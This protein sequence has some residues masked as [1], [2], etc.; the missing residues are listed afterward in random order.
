MDIRHILGPLK[1]SM[2]LIK[3]RNDKYYK[4]E[5]DKYKNQNL[6]NS[7][8]I[9]VRKNIILLT[10]C[11][12]QSLSLKRLRKICFRDSKFMKIIDAP[13]LMTG[14]RILTYWFSCV[15]MRR[16]KVLFDIS[17]KFYETFEDT[18]QR[19]PDTLLGDKDRRSVYLNK[20]I[21]L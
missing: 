18:L 19:F 13:T 14:F 10:R 9:Y 5:E 20:K 15:S 3:P 21:G 4:I 8:K 16:E 1:Y 11:H 6:W 7:V 17:G 2:L 12:G